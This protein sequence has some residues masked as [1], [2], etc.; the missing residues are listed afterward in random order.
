MWIF[1]ATSPWDG[2]R[3]IVDIQEFVC[4]ACP[5]FPPLC[6]ES[7]NNAE[8]EGKKGTKRC[9]CRWH[10]GCATLIERGRCCPQLLLLFLHCL[11]NSRPGRGKN[12]R[13]MDAWLGNRGCHRAKV[14][15]ELLLPSVGTRWSLGKWKCREIVGIPIPGGAPLPLMGRKG[16]SCPCS[17]LPHHKSRLQKKNP[18]QNKSP[19]TTSIKSNKYKCSDWSEGKQSTASQFIQS[20]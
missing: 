20:A 15:R 9:K 19:R 13:G 6:S 4:A 7:C 11:V 14:L 2:A 3:L 1:G 8:R 10:R 18:R 12:H 5:I 16:K 17:H